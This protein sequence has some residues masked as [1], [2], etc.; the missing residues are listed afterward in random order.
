MSLRGGTRLGS[1]EILSS[2]GTGAMGEVFRAKDL[3]LGREVA[4]K[5]LRPELAADA[6]RLRRFEQEARAASALNHPNIVHIYD[7]G[8]SDGTHY[9][10]MELIEGSTLRLL[11]AEATPLEEERILHIGRQ[12]ADG[13]AKA[14]SAGIVHRDLK[15]ENVMVTEEGFV[16]IV[17][18]GL[19]KLSVLAL[20]LSSDAATLARTRQGMLIGTVEYMSPEQAS[21]K[22]A[23]HRS[24][25]FSLGLILY[26][27]ATGRIAFHRDTAAQTLAAI[28]ESEPP[29]ISSVN[30]RPPTG[31][32][33]V[34]RRCLE[35]DPAQRYA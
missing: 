15:P 26:E 10:A 23:D 13:L 4:I 29:S 27:M 32:D 34:V 12:L 19:A 6:E 28:I 18:F 30:R 31:L 8:E 21:G 14:H 17:D 3:K 1:F 11:L 16:K 20:E 9:I 22:S 2:L 7:V 24:D 33:A 35:K 5:V 25:Q